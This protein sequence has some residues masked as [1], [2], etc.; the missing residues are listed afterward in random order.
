LAKKIILIK[1]FLIFIFFTISICQHTSRI[2]IVAKYE[3]NMAW[4]NPTLID[5]MFFSYDS[6]NFAGFSDIA[7]DCFDV[8]F[9]VIEPPLPLGNWS[10]L[11]FPHNDISLGDC[12]E[13]DFNVNNFTQDI[14]FKDN[15][16]LES[17]YYTWD[18]E[19]NSY[20]APGKVKLFLINT[21]FWEDCNFKFEYNGDLINH[22]ENDTLIFW[23]Y[24]QGLTSSNEIKFSIGECN[25][26]S[27]S[28]EYKNEISS[29]NIYPN[30]FNS[31]IQIDYYSNFISETYIS[32]N[33][34][35]G[36]IIWNDQII[37]NIGLN[38]INY[39][40]SPNLASGIYILN[41]NSDN[42]SVSQ[43]IINLK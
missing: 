41:I 23:N 31:Y 40:S 32:I 24:F 5:S 13:N 33:D 11:T 8:G 16:I 1:N 9:D 25:D 34:L 28:N 3:M 35:N 38:N 27:I 18:L 22:S 36:K 10:R 21:E 26:L 30:P 29:I 42:I 37:S 43:Y 15:S 19:F 20:L 39:N 7:T 14:R 4:I 6:F 17:N 2:Q 12:W